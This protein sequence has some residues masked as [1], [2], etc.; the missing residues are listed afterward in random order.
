MA[1]ILWVYSM[2]VIL[3]RDAHSAFSPGGLLFV[4]FAVVAL[5]AIPYLWVNRGLFGISVAE[6]P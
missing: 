5:W 1:N 6:K 2:T 4:P 3:Y